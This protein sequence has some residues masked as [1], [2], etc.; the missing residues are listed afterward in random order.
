MPRDIPIPLPLPSDG[1]VIR[2]PNKDT[3]PSTPALWQAPSVTARGLVARY[4][5]RHHRQEM[6]PVPRVIREMYLRRSQDRD[7]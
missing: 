3:L 2:E 5:Q 6:D 1:K 7:H 4:V